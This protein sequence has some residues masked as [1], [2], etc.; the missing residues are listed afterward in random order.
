[1]NEAQ[2]DWHGRALSEVFAPRGLSLLCRLETADGQRY[3]VLGAVR[4]IRA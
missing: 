1:M 4:R 2:L 3:G